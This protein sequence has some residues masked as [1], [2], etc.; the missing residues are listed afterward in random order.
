MAISMLKMTTKM[1]LQTAKPSV[2][3]CDWPKYWMAMKSVLMR[4]QHMMNLS[5]A[6]VR[7]ILWHVLRRY[8][9]GKRRMRMG[10]MRSRIC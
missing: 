2:R 9:S 1:M 4:M 6:S 10:E 3:A 7:I 8:P 5:A